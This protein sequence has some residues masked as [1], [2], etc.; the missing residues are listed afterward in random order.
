MPF[1][2]KQ[3]GRMSHLLKNKAKI[4]TVRKDRKTY[5]AFDFDKRRRDDTTTSKENLAKSQT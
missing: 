5:D 4:V 2:S 1:I 3:K